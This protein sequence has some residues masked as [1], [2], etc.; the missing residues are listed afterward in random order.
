M[1]LSECNA[2]TSLQ[3]K[4]SVDVINRLYLLNFTWLL[5]SGI[6]IINFSFSENWL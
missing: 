6:I 4:K 1:L 5:K 3:N 2:T